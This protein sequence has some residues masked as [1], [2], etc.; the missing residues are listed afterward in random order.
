MVDLL[1]INFVELREMKQNIC[2]L[3]VTMN[4]LHVTQNFEG[5]E[6]LLKYYLNFA[7]FK[8]QAV[9]QEIFKVATVAIVDDEVEVI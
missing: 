6:H 2:V 3:D 4:N 5:L 9:L 1:T 8:H 7:F